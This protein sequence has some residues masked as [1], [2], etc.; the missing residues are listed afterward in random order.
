M[1][2]YHSAT[3]MDL[4]IM[5]GEV[6]QREKDKDDICDISNLKKQMI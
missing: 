1:K 6:S 3:W 4:D 5:L 2:E